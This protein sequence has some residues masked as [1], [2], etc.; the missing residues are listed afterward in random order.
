HFAPYATSAVAAAVQSTAPNRAD[1]AAAPGTA[2]GTACPYAQTRAARRE[3]FYAGLRSITGPYEAIR[4]LR[5]TDP[6]R[7][8]TETDA[9]I[10]RLAVLL[11]ANPDAPQV[12]SYARDLAKTTQRL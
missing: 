1:A 7:Y 2:A 9:Y 3:V 12:S 10:G 8:V 4:G 6:A 5:E 11:H